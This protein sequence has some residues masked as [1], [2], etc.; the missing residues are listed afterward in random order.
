[1]AS[2]IVGAVISQAK[3]PFGYKKII[4]TDTTALFSTEDINEAH[5]LCAIINSTVVRDFIKSYSSAGRGFGAP[6]VM[7]PVGINKFNIKNTTHKKLSEL[8][9]T[10]HKLK[11]KSEDTKILQLEKQVDQLVYK[12][13]GLPDI[14]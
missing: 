11:A 8:S 12:L 4:P 6:S 1:M 9:K 3:T 14:R 7:D 2:D 5:Y 10:L 13:F